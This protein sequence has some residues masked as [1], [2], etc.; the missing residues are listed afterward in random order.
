MR[1]ILKGLRYI[2]FSAEVK[3]LITYGVNPVFRSTFI[4]SD[5]G[6]RNYALPF[7]PS[8]EIQQNKYQ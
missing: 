4:H 2:F 8:L 7:L 3:L 5:C 1:I 6:K